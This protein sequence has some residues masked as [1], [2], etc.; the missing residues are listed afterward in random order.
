MISLLSVLNRKCKTREEMFTKV[1]HAS[2]LHLKNILR[3]SMF[4]K[5]MCP[6]TLAYYTQILNLWRKKFYSIGHWIS[7][8]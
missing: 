7:Y 8:A 3:S 4:G 5:K 2:L 6:I 1:K